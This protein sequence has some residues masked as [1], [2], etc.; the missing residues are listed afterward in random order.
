V[1]GVT[2]GVGVAEGVVDGVGELV[3]VG[4]GER[5]G[6]GVGEG[7]AVSEGV[8]LGV[9]VGEEEVPTVALGDG[10]DITPAQLTA[11]PRGL[12]IPLTPLP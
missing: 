7:V 1:E 11:R 5:V 9:G 10:Q 4:V 8:E 6:D 3:G 12:D 2:E